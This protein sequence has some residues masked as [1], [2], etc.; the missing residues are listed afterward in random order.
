METPLSISTFIFYHRVSFELASYALSNF[1][2]K[3]KFQRVILVI[4]DDMY[5]VG[6]TCETFKGISVL[7]WLFDVYY[8]A[9][10]D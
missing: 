8:Q 2:L 9:H 7:R 4:N 5:T 3:F 1:C 10:P 6:A